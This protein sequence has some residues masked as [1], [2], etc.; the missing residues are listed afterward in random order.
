M[1]KHFIG[2]I[3]LSSNMAELQIS[4][5]SGKIIEAVKR[6][7][8]EVDLRKSKQK[9]SPDLVQRTLEQLQ[10]FNQ[11]LR[12]YGV[13]EVYLFGT[14]RLS[15]IVNAVYLVDQIESETGLRL[16]WLNANQESY[17]RQIAMRANGDNINDML[18]QNVF[19]M[20]MTSD[21]LDLGY[22]EA[23]QFRF[24]QH[25]AI[26]PIRL[27][28][29]IN[30]LAVETVDQMAFT[31]EYISSKM[32]DFWHML[33]EHQKSE[34]LII[35]GSEMLQK[36]LL[37]DQASSTFL[38]QQHL[39]TLLHDF[40][41]MSDQAV[42]DS[43]HIEVSQVPFALTEMLLVE[44]VRQAI[45][46]KQIYIV[47]LNVLDGIVANLSRHQN[48][49]KDIMTAA[50]GISDRYL[51]ERQHRDVV[52]DFAWQLFDRL[53]RVH[54][55]E[56]RDRLL[57]GVA[58]LVHDV[59]SFIN[60]QRHYQYS[61]EILKGIDFYGLSTTEQ[62]M[63]A[64]IARYHSAEVPDSNLQE[65]QEFSPVQRIRIAKLSALLRLADALDDSR[66]QKIT[67]LSI[68]LKDQNIVVVASSEQDLQLEILV[69][70]Q[71][72][73]FFESVFGRA[74]KLKQRRQHFS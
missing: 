16:K 18:A 48:G 34:T 74:V 15:R 54:R 10:R 26:G 20:G 56:N 19:V 9:F 14:E 63:I 46:A 23:Q 52:L 25:S 65:V 62:R 51:V 49:E 67:K 5:Q 24:N 44:H 50:R 31:N 40:N 60:S 7:L 12:D 22:Y 53:K 39:D 21:R 70:N 73:R 36:I 68:S 8:T 42:S 17:Y 58:A 4:N 66:R 28:Q 72:A 2:N 41:L 61:E 69:F 57:L 32:A 59:G 1:V 37:S 30:Q 6:N 3:L 43:Y 47:R 71:K 55:L 38:N 27:A 45:G 35:Q 29:T 64:A 11:L 33:P 13:I